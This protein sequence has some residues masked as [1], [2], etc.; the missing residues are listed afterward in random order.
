[1]EKNCRPFQSNPRAGN[2]ENIQPGAV[3]RTGLCMRKTFIVAFSGL[4]A[5]ISL[6]PVSRAQADK[7]ELPPRIGVGGEKT[8]SLPEAIEMALTNNKDIESALIDNQVAR[9]TLQAARGAY[10]LKFSVQ[11]PFARSITPMASVL[12]GAADGR[13]M[14]RDVSVVPQLN[15]SIPWTGGSFGL[16][17]SSKRTYTNNSFSTLNPQYPS[18]LTFSFTQPLLRGLRFDS[19]RQRI[20][21]TRKNV[22]L[23]DEQFRQRVIDTVTQTAKAYW[24]LVF[25]IQNLDVQRIAAETARRQAESNRRMADQGIM[26]PIDIVEAETQMAQFEQNAYTA[27]ANLTMAE[28]SIKNLT[29]TD[30]TSPLWSSRLIPI[31]EPESAPPEMLLADAIKDALESRPELQEIKIAAD[32]SKTNVRYYREQ[33]KPQVDLVASYMS[34]GLAGVVSASSSP[35]PFLGGFSGMIERI[36]ELSALQNLSPI[37]LSSGG[38]AGGSGIPPT[39]IGG[40]GQ[41]LSN[42]SGWNYPTAQ[43]SLQISLPLRNRTAEGNLK[44]GLAEVQRSEVRRKQIEQQIEVDVRNSMQSLASL[45]NGLEAARIARRFAQEQ[46]ASE[47][48]KFKAGTSTLFLVLQRQTTLVTAQSSELRAQVDLAKATAEYDRATGRILKAHNIVLQ[49]LK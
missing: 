18:S 16:S 49:P 12:G 33:T 28:N 9:F 7:I 40:Y 38:S 6:A 30:R 47:Q 46:F 19:N 35:N 39:L 27:Q 44:S 22:L 3:N 23:S 48:R 31:T 37:N 26:A 1:M 34:S 15:G 45:K 29:L 42:L 36:N 10:D 13:L 25:A 5:M 20:E 43:V 32:I 21:V 11:S 14:Q 17:F 41:S 2:I 4:L 8:I 24:D